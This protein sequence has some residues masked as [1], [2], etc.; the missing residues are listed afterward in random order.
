MVTTSLPKNNMAAHVILNLA[1]LLA[2]AFTM[3]PHYNSQEGFR[4]ECDVLYRE[5]PKANAAAPDPNRG[6]PTGRRAPSPE[7]NLEKLAEEAGLNGLGHPDERPEVGPST[8]VEGVS[9]SMHA[10]RHHGP[11][12]HVT[13]EVQAR[14]EASANAMR[15]AEVLKGAEGAAPQ[16][17]DEDTRMTEAAPARRTRQLMVA[18]KGRFV[19]KGE[20]IWVASQDPD[21]IMRSRHEAWRNLGDEREII[22]VEEAEAT[23]SHRSLE[24]IRSSSI[25]LLPLAVML[26]QVDPTLASL[27]GPSYVKDTITGAS[28]A[29]TQYSMPDPS[30]AAA[31]L[32]TPPQ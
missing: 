6:H 16:R 26:G 22:S 30:L 25:P 18:H 12:V 23:L 11:A 5:R 8:S 24:A 17:P 14:A 21:P 4:C 31:H 9:A 7:M 1:V 28:L 13:P 27:P 10:L 32:S 19:S 15:K 3:L 20:A 2:L 29:S